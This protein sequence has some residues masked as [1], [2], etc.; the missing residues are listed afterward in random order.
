MKNDIA[1]KLDKV[2]KKYCKSLRR[3]IVYGIS[4]IV[5]NVLGL[6]ALSY[7]LRPK[8]FWA[9]DNISFELKKGE[10]LG[11]IGP[12]G[13]GKTTLL[14]MINGIF[15][16]DQGKI[17]VRGKVGSL[18]EVGAGFHP[19]LTG[20]ENIYIGGAILGLT[21]QEIDSQLQSII[22][23]ADIDEFIDVPVKYYSSGMYVRLG[24]AIA[25]HCKPDILLIDEVLAVGDTMF[26]NKCYRQLN[27]IKKEKNVAIIFVSHD[28]FAI[29]KF[30]D[31]GILLAKGI[32]KSQGNIKKVI[33]DYQN[34]TITQAHSHINRDNTRKNL[35]KI[36]QTFITNV[37]L[38]NSNYQQTQDFRHNEDL[39]IKIEY[40]TKQPISSPHFE[41]SIY[42]QTGIKICSLDTSI[43]QISTKPLAK[44]ADWI[45][46][47]IQ[48]LPLLADA[49]YLA[50]HMYDSDHMTLLDYWDNH[51]SPNLSFKVLSNRVSVKM[52]Q[53]RGICH[54][55]TKWKI[56][57]SSD[58]YTDN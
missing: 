39:G 36:K 26:R 57:K 18:I 43:D 15:W 22:N 1:I 28:L 46:C 55:N 9:V 48:N 6:S 35:T 40:A 11:I 20:R 25:V 49:Y 2:S 21:K 33:I 19:L 3:S 27:K 41:M 30:C 23:F 51:N 7:H 24:F 38:L 58:I 31:K 12:N 13:S 42:N 34:F 53:Y 16:P 44:G 14:K 54:F 45:E 50:V 29:E 52:G 17:S 47:W 56:N 4:D 8:E 37:V 10:S 32:L 5:R